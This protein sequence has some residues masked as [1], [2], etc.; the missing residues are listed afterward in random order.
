MATPNPIYIWGNYNCPPA[1]L[2]TT[3][4]TASA[5]ASVAGDAVTFLSPSW[6]DSGS[7]S[8]YSTELGET[9]V[10]A[11]YNTAMIA[12]NVPSTGTGS[13]NY[14]GGVNNLPR[15]LEDWSSATLTANTSFVCLFSST[16]ATVT[17]FSSRS[18]L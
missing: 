13:T 1:Y 14:S 3:N 17:P 6:Q 10:S 4:T 12:G 18:S 7:T 16:W 5:P 15:L 9:A 11:T 8:S 2:G